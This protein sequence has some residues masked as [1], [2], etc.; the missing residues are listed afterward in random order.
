MFVSLK[1]GSQNDA[2]PCVSVLNCENDALRQNMA[3]F[4]ALGS[5]HS[6]RKPH[7]LQDNVY[8]YML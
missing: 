2:R 7:P 4:T 5:V 6:V 3:I 1:A 8:T